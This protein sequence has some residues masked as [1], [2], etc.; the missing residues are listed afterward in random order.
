MTRGVD[1]D[2]NVLALAEHRR[3]PEAADLLVVKASTG[4]GAAIIAGGRLQRGAAGATGEIGHVKVADAGGAACRCGGVDC[5]EAVAGGWAMA[6]TL[7]ELGKP[8][9]DALGIA[10]LARAGD[11][12]AVRLVRGAGQRIGEVLAG[13]VNLLNPALIV[14]GGDLAHAFEPLV[15]GI[16]E[17][18]Y[19]RST[20]MAT[21]SLGIESADMDEQAGVSAVAI[22]VLDDV[23]SRR[24]VDR[25]ISFR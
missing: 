6:R 13:A 10:E 4:I 2:V 20:A 24:S 8:V 19:Q 17:L 11:P 12:D 5:L 22:L 16:R 1:N 23:L 18:V 25:L 7:A 9:D 14:V 3:H 15:A 21:R